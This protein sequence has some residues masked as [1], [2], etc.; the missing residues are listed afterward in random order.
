MSAPTVIRIVAQN[1]ADEAR[2]LSP[3]EGRHREI[4]VDEA[5][6][7]SWLDNFAALPALEAEEADARLYLS[8]AASR[9]EVRW[10]G[11]HLGSE[12]GGTF[13]PATVNEIIGQ[14]LSIPAAAEPEPATGTPSQEPTPPTSRPGRRRANGPML[15]GLL[16]IFAVIIWWNTRP[17]MPEGTELIDSA[18]ERQAILDKAAGRYASDNERLSLDAAAGRLTATNGSGEQTLSTAL[19]VGRKA[20]VPVL[21]TESGVVLEVAANGQLRLGAVDYR[22][23]PS[24]G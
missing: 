12:I 2:A 10:F 20:G 23:L 4:E 3:G 8:V 1:L 11:G 18:S 5:G 7:R 9:V 17:E 24:G 6:L 15:A 21:V 14:A 22:R 13:L 19:R 16:A